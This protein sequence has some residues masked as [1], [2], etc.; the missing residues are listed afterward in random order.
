M[1]ALKNIVINAA[2]I[3]VMLFGFMPAALALEPSFEQVKALAEQ[4]NPLGQTLLGSYYQ[5]GLGVRQDHSKAL[6][7]FKK[8]AAQN[9]DDAQVNIGAIYDIGLG[10]RQN[11]ATAKEWFGKAC[12]NGN[13][14]GCNKYKQ[15]NEQG[16]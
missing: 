14:I 1:Q 8:A 15:L 9:S 6:E 2:M 3:L 10:V 7:W 5:N 11:K 16:Y 4:D 12:D 13:Q